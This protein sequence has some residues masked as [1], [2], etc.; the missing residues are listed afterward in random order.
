MPNDGFLIKGVGVRVIEDSTWRNQ[1]I[2]YGLAYRAANAQ[3]D[4]GR[5][6]AFLLHEVLAGVHRT[7]GRSIRLLSRIGVA[8][9][10]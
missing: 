2:G 4:A 8:D 7:F 10:D 6:D 5:I 1:C 9:H 3:F